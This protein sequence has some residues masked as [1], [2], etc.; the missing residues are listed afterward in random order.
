MDMIL[1]IAFL[2]L[3]HCEQKV[4]HVA[5]RALHSYAVG[6]AFVPRDANS[7]GQPRSRGLAET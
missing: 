4:I 5:G 1:P 2:R 7:G 6:E 3:P